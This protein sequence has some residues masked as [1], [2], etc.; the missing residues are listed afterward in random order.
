MALTVKPGREY[1]LGG[2]VYKGGEPVPEG[3][4]Q[5]KYLA[6]LTSAKGPLSEGPATSRTDLPAKAMVAR[7]PE[8]AP[9]PAAEPEPEEAAPEAVATPQTYER[10]D[11]VAKPVG[12]TGPAEPSRSSH[13]VRRQKRRT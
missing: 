1:V 7:E 12:Q 8:P 9:E 10:R 2:K 11:M 5:T 4:I 3:Q 6:L 13:P